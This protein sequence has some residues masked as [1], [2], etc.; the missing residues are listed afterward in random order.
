MARAMRKCKAC[1]KLFEPADVRQKTCSPECHETLA[2]EFEIARDAKAKASKPRTDKRVEFIPSPDE[3][4]YK[5]ALIRSGKVVISGKRVIYLDA[6]GTP[7][8]NN[9]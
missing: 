1:R 5:T 7:N 2:K 3:I 8:E 9:D 4:A 6:C